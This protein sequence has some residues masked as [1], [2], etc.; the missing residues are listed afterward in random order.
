MRVGLAFRLFK[1]PDLAT[2]GSLLN[3]GFRNIT[4][5]IPRRSKCLAK[6]VLWRKNVLK[7]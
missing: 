1:V 7:T 3:E 5:L 6:F 2:C 4:S